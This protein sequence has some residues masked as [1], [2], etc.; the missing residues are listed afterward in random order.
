MKCPRCGNEDLELIST[1]N[2]L[3][4]YC[5]P[6]DLRF[7]DQGFGLS[8]FENSLSANSESFRKRVAASLRI[9][10]DEIE[11]GAHWLK[12]VTFGDLGIHIDYH[13]A[14]PKK[15]AAQTL[16]DCSCYCHKLGM[17][18]TYNCPN[19]DRFHRQKLEELKK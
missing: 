9:H 15:T 6:C 14:A 11:R 12:N 18:F 3:R 7:D 5:K 8:E 2:P 17:R 19:C 13:Q 16:H 4:N 10:A 1:T